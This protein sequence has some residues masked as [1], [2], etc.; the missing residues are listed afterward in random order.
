MRRFTLP[1]LLV[2]LVLFSAQVC[3]GAK[4][5]RGSGKIETEKRRVKGITGVEL[6]TL[7][8]LYIELGTKEELIIEAEDNILQYLKTNVSSGMLKITKQ[9][10]V[11]L[12]PKKPIKYY[13]TVKKLKKIVIS[14]A[15]D[16]E[17]P[18]LQA[19]RFFIKSSS[20]GHLEV[21][22][23]DA[24]T[25]DIDMSSVGDVTMGDVNAE[26]VEVSV[27]SAGEL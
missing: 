10:R 11:N 17:A 24:N 13:L 22:D 19:D 21:G 18:D 20:S 1:L 16:V 7:G 12:R 14:S 15:G 25:L 26:R 9:R 4:K 5:V 23:R 2:A 8:R 27:T 3:M 6:A